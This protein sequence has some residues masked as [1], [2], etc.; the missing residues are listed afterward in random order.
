MLVRHLALSLLLLLG[1]SPLRVWAETLETPYYRLRINPSAK[2]TEQVD[3]GWEKMM[4]VELDGQ[5]ARVRWKPDGFT[6]IF[7]DAT[8][9]TVVTPPGASTQAYELITDFEGQRYRIRKSA[10]EV[11]WVLPGQEVF[12]RTYGGKIA[13][14]LGSSD[15]LKVTRD[16]KGGRIAVES[17]AGTSDVLLRK[18]KLE[19]FDGPELQSHIYFVRGLAFQRGPI[20][21]EIPLPAEPFLNALP[22]DRYLWVKGKATSP[23]AEPDP[24]QEQPLE[25]GQSPMDPLEAEPSSWESPVY[26]AN[27]GDAK[28]DPLNARREVRHPSKHDPLRA[29][30]TPDSEEVLRVKDY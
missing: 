14:V 6:V 24:G 25:Q 10:R 1:S 19:V 11:G 22:A 26:R 20:T 15:F 8:L 4:T 18:G 16:T 23:A 29:T 17:N 7:P 9:R 12:F 27:Q 13:S 30:T 28:E 21:L 2:I 5:R 3:T